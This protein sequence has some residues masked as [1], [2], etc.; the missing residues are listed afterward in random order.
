MSGRKHLSRRGATTIERL[1]ALL[2]KSAGPDGCWI[3]Q[4]GIYADG[5]GKMQVGGR[6]GGRTERPHR[7]MLE[8]ALG[9]SPQGDVLHS[10]SNR[11]CCNP[12]HLSED[13]R[14]VEGRFWSKVEKSDGCWWWRGAV[15]PH[16]YG[17]FKAEAG[18]VRAHRFAISAPEGVV[19]MHRCDNR[20]C[21]NPAHLQ[22]GTHSENMRDMVEKGRPPRGVDRPNAKL[23][24]EDVVGIRAAAADGQSSAAIAGSLPVCR[25]TVRSVIAGET[26]GHV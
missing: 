16:G 14:T 10:C 11:A 8:H 24:D 9:R 2:D 6:V 12:A 23:R 19:V 5:Y 4:R 20:R 21:V 17:T 3:W 25:S 22:L 1:H 26:W 15:G 13:T 18:F 7:V